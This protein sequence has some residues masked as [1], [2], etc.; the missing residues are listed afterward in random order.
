M[1]VAYIFLIQPLYVLQLARSTE[2]TITNLY[3]TE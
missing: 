2:A 1:G 3:L